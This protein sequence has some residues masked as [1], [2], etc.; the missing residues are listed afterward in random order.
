[1]GGGTS[2]DTKTVGVTN[3]CLTVIRGLYPGVCMRQEFS[4][5]SLKRVL[6]PAC[7]SHACYI[8][9]K[10]FRGTT[11]GSVLDSQFFSGL[12]QHSVLLCS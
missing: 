4:A 9:I 12:D 2:A 3:T 7:Q 5:L 11:W 8:Q 10:V 1:M 6:F